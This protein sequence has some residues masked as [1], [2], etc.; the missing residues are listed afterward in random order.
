MIYAFFIF[1]LLGIFLIDVRPLSERNQ[2]KE[3]YVILII[4]ALALI[5]SILLIFKVEVPSPLKLF[6]YIVRDVLGISFKK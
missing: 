1:S 2:K 6:I 3:I 4:L 5:L